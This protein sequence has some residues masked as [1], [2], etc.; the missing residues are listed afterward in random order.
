M[1]KTCS[2]HDKIIFLAGFVCL[3]QRLRYGYICFGLLAAF[4]TFL[5][6]CVPGALV[7]WSNDVSEQKK[8]WGGY[9]RDAIYKLKADMFIRNRKD[10]PTPAES[11]LVA[12]AKNTKGLCYLHYSVPSSLSDY[13]NNIDAWPDIVG[14]VNAGTRIQC[15]KLIK[16][17]PL[18]F[19]SSL[20]IKA[21]ILDG[22]F[23]GKEV[24]ITDLSTIKL[25]S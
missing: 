13:R 1:K 8:L 24:E 6:G 22:P 15:T 16:Y 4:L 20:Y 25:D 14:V 5:S 12:P 17:T 11:V 19:G 3:S 2:L 10:I 18:G 23:A 7:S 9:S 21:V